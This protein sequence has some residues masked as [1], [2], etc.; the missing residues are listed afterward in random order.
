MKTRKLAV[1]TAIA[2]A[3]LGAARLDAQAPDAN[4]ITVTGEAEV[5]VV[6]DEVVLRL[7][8]Q[9]GDRDLAL[10]KRTN[11]ERVTR[12]L[13][14]AKRFVPDP[15]HIQTDYM[16]I[17][18]RYR[19]SSDVVNDLIGYVVRKSIV[20]T[21]KDTSKFEELLSAMLDAGVNHVHGVDFR[22]SELRKHR[23]QAR[24]LAIRAAQEKATALASAVGRKAGRARS[25]S[26]G[27]FGWWSG[28]GSG[29]G[30]GFGRGMAQNVVQNAGGAALSDEGSVALGQITVRGSVSATFA[31][32]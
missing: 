19:G 8:V 32:E 22:T 4:A 14:A 12:A 1:L 15:K 25:I 23:D 17:D 13:A 6:P 10:A 21:L 3:A 18:P 30:G 7:G 26:E 2:V 11:D 24:A 31:L 20:V 28:Y 29:W 9:T 5:K 16:A 27:S